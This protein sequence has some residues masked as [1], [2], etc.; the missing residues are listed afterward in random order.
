M[1]FLFYSRN[2]NDQFFYP[3]NS[4]DSIVDTYVGRDKAADANNHKK[5]WKN[6][7]NHERSRELEKS[8]EYDD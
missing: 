4:D 7:I 2:V 8:Y 1:I 5:K 6:S 3:S